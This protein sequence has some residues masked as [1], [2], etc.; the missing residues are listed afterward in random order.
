MTVYGTG[1]QTRCFTYIDD[2]VKG[3]LPCMNPAYD[4]QVFNIGTTH[5]ININELAYKIKRLSN[6]S[7]PIVNVSY[8]KAYGPG[9]EDMKDRLPDISKA[10][11]MLGYK[12][13]VD[14][15]Q[16]LLTT[17]SWYKNVN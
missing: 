11:L 13:Q 7:S 2:V 10:G 16:G 4:K 1:E 5:R 12:P 17:I 15:E 9:Y 3:L 14:I 8:V 6:S